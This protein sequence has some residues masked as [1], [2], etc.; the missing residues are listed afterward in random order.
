M[1]NAKIAGKEKKKNML[2]L[3]RTGLGFSP[4]AKAQIY[5]EAK[6][7]RPGGRAGEEACLGVVVDAVGHG[8]HTRA[9]ARP[10]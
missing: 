6:A 7:G 1:D 8:Q 10:G 4:W 2:N 9:S 5:G 3:R